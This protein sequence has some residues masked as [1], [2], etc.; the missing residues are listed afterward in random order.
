MAQPKPPK[1]RS[2]VTKVRPNRRPRIKLTI[3]VPKATNGKIDRKEFE[4]YLI[5]LLQRFADFGTVNRAS[6]GGLHSAGFRK[7]PGK[8]TELEL[9]FWSSRA[10]KAVNKLRRTDKSFDDLP[11]LSDYK[12]T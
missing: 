6:L 10:K 1:V 8:A 3:P 2:P 9:W 12:E 7:V 4:N 11:P 5:D